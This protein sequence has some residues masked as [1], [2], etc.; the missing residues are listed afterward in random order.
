[1][2]INQQ[3]RFESA[4]TK[5]LSQAIKGFLFFFLSAQFFLISYIHRVDGYTHYIP[6]FVKCLKWQ[7]KLISLTKKKEQF[8]FP[9]RLLNF[10]FNLHFF[11]FDLFLR[12]FVLSFFPSV[13]FGAFSMHAILLSR[14]LLTA[15][16]QIE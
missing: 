1:M 13:N 11:S 4:K 14:H 2:N 9:N 5:I 7:K 16:D 12:Y 3:R 8:T 6:I 10:D 15:R